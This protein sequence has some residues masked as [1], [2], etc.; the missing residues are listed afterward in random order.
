MSTE[1]WV[2]AAPQKID[3]AGVTEVR[4]RLVEGRA[5]TVTDDAAS[6]VRVEVVEV[7]SRPLQLVREGGV[8]RV[9]Y[10]GVRIQGWVDRLR[11][12]SQDAERAVVRVVAPPSVRLDVGTVG[13]VA[14]VTG[15]E[16]ARVKTVTGAIRTSGTSGALSL[17]TI[18]G[19]VA[20]T[21]H[22]GDVSVSIVSGSLAVEGTLGRVTVSTVSGPVAITARGSVPLVDL[23]SVSGPAQVRLD[24]GTPVNLRVRGV[25]GQAILDGAA[26]PS[27]G[28]TLAVDHA[29]APVEGRAPAYVSAA[30]T[31]GT[32]SVSRG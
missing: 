32:V 3:V 24:V 14:D 4:L 11:G 21:G 28:R 10:D 29:D 7:G 8:L 5:E 17:R 26:L 12:G 23:K 9:G 18:S 13:A 22:V 27:Q 19:D 2:V 1:S 6:G 20:A 25:S 16:G 15:A 31:T 30:V